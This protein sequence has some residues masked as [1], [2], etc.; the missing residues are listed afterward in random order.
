LTGE[1]EQVNP[2][3]IDPAEIIRRCVFCYSFLAGLTDE[4]KRLAAAARAHKR[5]DLWHK[6]AES[7]RNK[8]GPDEFEQG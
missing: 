2:G 5:R 3:R 1:A 7:C 8:K 6:L 4:E